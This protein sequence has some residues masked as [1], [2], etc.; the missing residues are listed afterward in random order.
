MTKN[1][2]VAAVVV[3]GTLS[4]HEREICD[5]SSTAVEVWV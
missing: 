1:G 5:M 3:T 2:K 4:V